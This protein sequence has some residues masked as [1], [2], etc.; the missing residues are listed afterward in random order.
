MLVYPL[1]IM[2]D[3]TAL[4]GGFYQGFFKIDGD[5]YQT[6]PHQ[7]TDEWNF[8]ITLRKRDYETPSNILN[9][10]HTENQGMF[11]FIGTR[12]ENK[13][14]ELYKSKPEMNNL[15]YDDSDDYSL[16]YSIMDSNV[17]EQQYINDIPDD[18][19]KIAKYGTRIC[20]K[21]QQKGAPPYS[22]CCMGELL[23]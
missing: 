16:D 3:Y 8:N 6:L 17:T 15:K 1:E 18:D 11:F 4:K 23:K 9:K 20:K 2:N 5:K 14:W 22:D 7:I 21:K 19:N 12:A 13:F 10:R